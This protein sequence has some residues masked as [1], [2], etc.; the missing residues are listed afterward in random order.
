MLYSRSSQFKKR[1]R[2]VSGFGGDGRD[3]SR[4]SGEASKRLVKLFLAFIARDTASSP[5]AA[6]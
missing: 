6:R 4:I 3:G 2:R 5:F 1:L